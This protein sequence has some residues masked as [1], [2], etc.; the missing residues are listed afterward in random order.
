MGL[1]HGDVPGYN[2]WKTD[3]WR[4]FFTPTEESIKQGTD[5]RKGKGGATFW[6]SGCG[7]K[8]EGREIITDKLGRRQWV[9]FQEGTLAKKT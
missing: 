7:E 9:F 4:R 2:K 3:V 8:R 6:A 5:R 1:K